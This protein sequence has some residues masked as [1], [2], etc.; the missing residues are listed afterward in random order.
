MIQCDRCK[1][2]YSRF[3]GVRFWSGN[4]TERTD[5]G[6]EEYRTLCDDCHRALVRQN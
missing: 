1:E 5:G 4:W 6:R 3:E 2:S